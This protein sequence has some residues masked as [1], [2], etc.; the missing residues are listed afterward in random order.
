MTLQ[1]PSTMAYV[2]VQDWDESNVA[3]WLHGL[4][5]QP[6]E[7]LKYCES[8]KNNQILGSRLLH[9]TVSDLIKLNVEK[10]GHQEIILEGLEKLKNLHYNLSTEN[11]QFIALKLSCKAR[12]LYNEICLLEN[13]TK[14]NSNVASQPQKQQEKVDTTTMSAVADVL[15]ALMTMLSWL[16]KP[17]FVALESDDDKPYKKFWKA[18]V[19][20][21][22]NLA[23]NAQRDNF[24]ENPVQVR[25]L[26]QPEK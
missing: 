2:N 21:G 7:T 10:L 18:Y 8:F 13:Q 15:D 19:N 24:A 6:A 17:P 16:D 23:T 22:I 26:G 5:L 20:L 1:N 3:E 12:S 25:G 9:L 14:S 11:L 4:D